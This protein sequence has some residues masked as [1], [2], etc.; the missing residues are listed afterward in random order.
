PQNIQDPALSDIL[1]VEIRV[2]APAPRNPQA[3]H[4][5][6]GLSLSWNREVCSQAIGYD[7]YRREGTYGYVWDTCETGVPPYTG[8]VYH[9]ST[10][11]IT[12]TTYLDTIDIKVGVQYCY[13]VVANFPDGSVS[14]ASEEFCAELPKSRPIIT[15]VDVLSTD[16]S[17][18]EI[19]IKWTPPR[20][21]D[22][23]AFPPPYSYVVERA[24][25]IDGSAF[26]Q[27]GTTSTFMDTTFTDQNLNTEQ[28][29]YN[30][31][32]ALVSNGAPAIYS[33]P[34][35]S[36]FL[37]LLPAD[38]IMV[39]Q[40]NHVTPWVNDTFVVFRENAPGVFDS[41]GF[42]TSN[43]YLDTG[44]VNGQEYCY[45]ALGI[46]AFTG[47]GLP[48]PLFNNSQIACSSPLD[49]AKPCA[50]EVT[51][52]A[53]CVARLL[54]LSWQDQPGFCSSDIIAYN[55]Y[56]KEKAADPWPSTPVATVPVSQKSYTV[57]PDKLV[58]CHAI[59][60]I[61]DATPPNESSLSNIICIEGCD[62]I[63]LP[64]VFT[65]NDGGTNLFF[66]A[67]RDADGNPIFRDIATFTIEVYNRWGGIVYTTDSP[68]EFVSRGWDGKDMNSGQDVADGVYF[69]LVVY[70]P[71]SSQQVENRQLK[72]S[73]HLFR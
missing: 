3:N 1:T 54:T 37:K 2:I 9:A 36:I 49:T 67:I 56:Y 72:G 7:V 26:V 34:A 69:Y 25:N 73:I 35:S 14:V 4:D 31:R 61:D 46:G 33:D 57:D 45:K 65:P 16:Q 30:Y 71:K 22:S 48:K 39:L 5:G 24:E 64:N 62:T 60:A 68:E 38:K 8:Y 70:T 20:E 52:T 43:S 32:V 11:S 19:D 29:G 58:G 27:V 59:S 10:S 15:N 50:P 28:T 47:T 40:F 23:A 13:M 53:D 41:I 51:Y 44:L 63:A 42:S 6:D 12:D 17:S 66:T 55:I 18:G 21:F